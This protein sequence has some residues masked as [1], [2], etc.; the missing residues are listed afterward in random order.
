MQPWIMVKLKLPFEYGRISGRKLD[1][2]QLICAK[3]GIQCRNLEKVEVTE[4]VNDRG[5]FQCKSSEGFTL[6]EGGNFKIMALNIDGEVD[7]VFEEFFQ[8]TIIL[9]NHLN[10]TL[11]VENV[12]IW[13][14]SGIVEELPFVPSSLAQFITEQ[15]LLECEIDSLNL[16]FAAQ[17]AV[18]IKNFSNIKMS[19][20]GN[21][22]AGPSDY[23]SF[24]VESEANEICDLFT[25]SNF[26]KYLSE[27]TGLP[28][29][30]PITPPFSRILSSAG[31]Y[32]I[33][34]GNYAEG[35]G[36]DCIFTYY[37]G[38]EDGF[39]WS[40]EIFGHIHYLDEEGSEIFQVPNSSNSLTLVYRTEGVVR[41]LENIKG[42]NNPP[43]IQVLA[44]FS[45][46]DLE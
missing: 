24:L 7:G 9:Q 23:R 13:N 16:K 34:H 42:I 36:L 38:N 45:V 41:F 39:E 12:R 35:L 2:E 46:L 25:N 14:L 8:E 10:L 44:T 33:L 5:F 20:G 22:R 15:L 19:F 6:V 32:Q 26:I 18:T 3:F 37:P 21:F 17:S 30:L 31:D 4:Q 11:F 27:V 28:L 40:E 29:G 1:N 43:L